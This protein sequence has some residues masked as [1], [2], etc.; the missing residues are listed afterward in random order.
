MIDVERLAKLAR[1]KLN[2]GESEKLQK[3]FEAILGYVSKLDEADLSSLE[4][5]TVASVEGNKNVLREDES[6]GE[7][8]N[9]GEKLLESSVLKR[10]NHI[11]VKHVF[12]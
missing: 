10:G 11:K 12:E 1:I 2:S 8:K 6:A 9:Y 4:N 3:E 5:E 7:I